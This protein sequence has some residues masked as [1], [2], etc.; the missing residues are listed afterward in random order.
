MGRPAKNLIGERFGKLTV[1]SATRAR[2]TDGG[3]YWIASC[4]CGGS[5]E[6]SASSL[7]RGFTRSCGCLVKESKSNIKLETIMDRFMDRVEMVTESGCWIW[8]GPLDTAGYGISGLVGSDTLCAHRLSFELFNGRIPSGAHVC[9]KCDTPCCV[10]P[11]HLFAGKPAAN[12]A[13]ARNKRALGVLGMVVADMSGVEIIGYEFAANDMDTSEAGSSDSVDSG[14][15]RA[16]PV[17]RV[18][19][20][21]GW[22]VSALEGQ[23][24]A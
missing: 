16:D 7:R 9:H 22:L 13:D 4:D 2:D 15:T 6:V 17:Q 3:A 19:G 10:N 5:K 12:F 8:L 20:V 23:R 24:A 18:R 14:D 1:V 21:P 11:S